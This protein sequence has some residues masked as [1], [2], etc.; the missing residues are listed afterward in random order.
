[1]SDTKM[2]IL[3]KG[4]DYAPT[5]NKVNEPELRQASDEF[6]CKMYFLVLSKWSN[7]RF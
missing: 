3:E 1:M 4:V 7:G 5:Q 6:S 2:K